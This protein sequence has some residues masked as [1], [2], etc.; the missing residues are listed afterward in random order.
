MPTDAWGGRLIYF[1]PLG[2]SDYVIISLGA[3]GRPGGEGEDA[4]IYSWD[5]GTVGQS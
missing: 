5:F 4:D 1:S 2:D 3:D